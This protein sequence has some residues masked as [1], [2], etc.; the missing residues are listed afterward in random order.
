MKDQVYKQKLV[1]IKDESLVQ[2]KSGALLIK[3]LK[4][5]LRRNDV[6]LSREIEI[7]LNYAY[8]NQF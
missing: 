8:E 3:E 6:I 5:Y 4:Y 2:I 1:D 7:A